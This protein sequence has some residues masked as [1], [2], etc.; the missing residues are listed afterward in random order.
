MQGES[1]NF[2][3]KDKDKDKDN[4]QIK[5]RRLTIQERIRKMKEDQD[6]KKKTFERRKTEYN[7]SISKKISEI[8]A[9]IKL[10][11]D[12]SK[13]IIKE[14]QKSKLIRGSDIILEE[15]ETF[16]VY[17]YP[18]VVFSQNEFK[19]CK[20]LLMIGNAKNDF[21]NAFINVYTNISYNDEIRYLI[22]AKENQDIITYDIKSKKS[23]IKYDIKI[24]S[25]PPLD[26]DNITLK[27]NLI[28]LFEKKIPRNSIHF[29]CFAFHENKMVM[30]EFEKI[31]YRF[32]INLF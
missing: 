16:K 2:N 6:N 18:K 10:K 28:Q 5:G 23:D 32:F 17:Q 8:N 31:F 30:N 19:N 29:I 25:I 21:I 27:K 3:D 13:P 7:F 9:N 12:Q 11:E 4:N 15:K 26:K 1:N 14:K 24:I 22:D 20:I